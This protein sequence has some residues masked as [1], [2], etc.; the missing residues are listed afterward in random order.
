MVLGP[1]APQLDQAA[2]LATILLGPWAVDRVDLGDV[3]MIGALVLLMVRSLNYGQA[4]QTNYT[5]VVGAEPYVTSLLH[6]LGDYAESR[7]ARGTLRPASPFVLQ[8]NDVTAGY[9]GKPVIEHVSLTIGVGESIGVIGPS[10]AGKS[11]LAAVLLG[12]LE[13]MGGVYSVG[14]EDSRAVAPDWWSEHVAFVPKE[15]RLFSESVGVN[16]DFFRGLSREALSRAAERAHL[17]RE[18]QSWSDGLDH[19]VGPRGGR[20]SGGQRQ[21][22]CIARALASD[23]AMLVLDEPTSA[24]DSEAEES[25]TRVIDDLHGTCTTIIIAHRLSTLESCDRVFLVDG[26]RVSEIGTGHDVRSR[27]DVIKLMDIQRAAAQIGD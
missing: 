26:G 3:A 23:P 8:L 11:T 24:L 1:M 21:R 22:V 27:E 4:F 17:G 12:L 25:I 10:G 14:G 6:A 5:S 18:L 9:G 7:P 19:R 15:P 16:V 20:L 2:G 13:P